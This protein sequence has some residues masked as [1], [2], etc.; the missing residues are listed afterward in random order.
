MTVFSVLAKPRSFVLSL[1]VVITA[2]FF[3]CKPQHH[4][5]VVEYMLV[6]VALSEHKSPEIRLS[7]IATGKRL[8]PDHAH[9]FNILEQDIRQNKQ[10]VYAA[11]VR[12]K[13]DAVYSVHFFGYPALA[14]LP[15]KVL[16]RLGLDPFKCFQA[17]NLAALFVLGLALY[18]LFGS[19]GKAWFGLLLFIGCGGFQYWAWSSPEMVS[20]SLLL[21]GLILYVTGAPVWGGLVAGLA[22]WQNP[23]ILFFFGFAPLLHLCVART[24]GEPLLAAIKRLVGLRQLAGLALGIALVALP[25]LFNLYQ[26]GVPNIIAKL[27]SESVFIS[28]TRLQSFFFDLNQGMLLGIPAVAAMLLLWGWRQQGGRQAVI[29]AG[30]IAFTLLLCIPAMAVFNWNSDAHGVMRYAFW[31][32][33][34][35]LFALLWRLQTAP[36]WPAALCA[37]VLLAQAA[38]TAYV[39]SYKY[40]E[41]SPLAEW[42][43]EKWPEHYH[44]E[45]E[46]FVERA[47]HN[48]EYIDAAQVYRYPATGT[49]IKH[50]YNRAHPLGEVNL[51]GAGKE[52]APGNQVTYTYR[53][54]SYVDGPV[55]CQ[56]EGTNSGHWRMAQFRE[57]GPNL[58]VSGWGDLEEGPGTW[59]GAWTISPKAQLRLVIPANLRLRKVSFS[60]HYLGSLTHTRVKIDGKDLGMMRL[61]KAWSIALPANKNAGDTVLLELEHDLPPPP[62]GAQD[63]RQLAFFLNEIVMR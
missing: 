47:N 42:V 50:V 13:H 35:L 23:T 38:S 49:P 34:P 30:C 7:D 12:G 9:V 5:D 29:L 24:A 18:R 48:D 20:A 40:T 21:A 22:A 3:S 37:A 6:T 1:L 53:D 27:Y 28:F 60:G 11:F 45:P 32:A 56:P 46:I 2:M 41:F 58:M 59:K 26:F 39:I 33:M 55:T 57:L 54:W 44:P 19:S 14:V 52:L 62:P 25:P 31:S 43:L 15:Y 36:R 8:S 10:D 16:T 51:C 4:G 63:P 61:N 17:V